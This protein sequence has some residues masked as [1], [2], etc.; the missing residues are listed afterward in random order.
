MS[1]KMKDVVKV[2]LGFIAG[3][4]YVCT[5]IGVG[6]ATDQWYVQVRKS[7]GELLDIGKPLFDPSTKTEEE[8]SE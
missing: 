1:I 2:G 5:K 3:G 8:T 7:N 6:T 4:L